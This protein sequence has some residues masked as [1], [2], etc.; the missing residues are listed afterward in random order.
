[1]AASSTSSATGS[2]PSILS[3]G[4][5][6]TASLAIAENNTVVTTVTATDPD[7]GTVIRYA[8]AGGADAALFQI[9]ATTGLL[10]FKSSPDAENPAD[11]NGDG[12][13]D[14][15]VAARD[16]TYT[17][18]Q[19]IAVTVTD[20]FDSMVHA[21][22]TAQVRVNADTP[23]DQVAPAMAATANGL[24][25]A[26]V[27]QQTLA[28]RAQF[29]AADGTRIGSELTIATL[30]GTPEAFNG[31]VLTQ[32]SG[33]N[34]VLAWVDINHTI[35]AQLIAPN[36]ALLGD[37]F[38]LVTTPT[39]AGSP[40]Q[41]ALTALP[42]GGFVA[43]WQ[44]FAGADSD[45]TAIR[46]QLYDATGN[47]LGAEIAVNTATAGNQTDPSISALAK[48]GFVVT[49]TDASGT[50]GDNSGTAVKG[51]VFSSSGAK[52]GSEL[53][54]NTHTSWNQDTASVLGLANGTFVVT[55]QDSTGVDNS[56]D[57]IK[58]QVF[59]ATG[60]KLGA[61]ILVSSSESS[62][63]EVQPAITAL[64][65][66]GFA[67]SWHDSGDV[68]LFAQL[69]YATGAKAGSVFKPTTDTVNTLQPSVL[70]GLA[71]GSLASL[72]HSGS[73]ALG[74]S[75]GSI[76]L[77]VDT[78]QVPAGTVT[79]TG[80]AAND[81]LNGTF[82]N[83]KLLGGDGADK[84]NG[85]SGTDT[86]VGGAGDDR[87]YG[88][89]GSDV[90]SYAGAAG[91]V[92]VS[93]AITAA[94]DTIGAGI[95]TLNSIENLGGSSYADHLTGSSGSNYLVG[96]N[97]NDTLDGGAGNDLLVGSA[98]ADTLTGGTGNDR[99]RFDVM[100]TSAHRDTITDFT[101]GQ[102]SIEIRRSVFT[103]LAGHAAGALTAG[104]LAL[105]PVATT[106]DQH[107]VYDQASGVLSYDA[108]G[109]GAGAAVELA[110][111]TGHP[112][113]VAGDIILI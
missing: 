84:L 18:T 24:V 37:A 44:A 6:D 64:A 75:D 10:S 35:K 72:W 14:V 58:A 106:P 80:S 74:D 113:L 61:E 38:S 82:Y 17:D 32:L 21:T 20:V 77:H 30:N 63:D 52:L 97:G 98:G 107:L 65:N 7:A 105:G 54:I 101:A 12:V 29:L 3:N 42:G 68:Q 87:L 79:I 53:L 67:I 95:D 69:F 100:E 51:Q 23:G 109:S 78:V 46:A 48:G 110:V 9:N 47:K 102:D 108:D 76:A 57:A 43:A 33:G 60:A 59:S 45:G 55:W 5:G 27:D 73:T 103:A 40:T 99:F 86:L 4:G 25:T 39:S 104:E 56:L 50:L 62:A 89:D 19:A 41:P 90:A 92:T 8:L 2:A 83:D 22:R 15:I 28:L 88:G 71:D 1:M 34:T 70:A 96:G 81:V 49:W 93:L 112:A 66:G 85:G 111:L 13:Y 94:Q 16:G 11:A 31:P 26:W 36:G 91:G